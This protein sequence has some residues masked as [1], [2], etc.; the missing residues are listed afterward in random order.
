MVVT[1]TPMHVTDTP[2]P[3]AECTRE[4]KDAEREHSSPRQACHRLREH[5]HIALLGPRGP[6]DPTTNL[7]IRGRCLV[8]SLARAVLS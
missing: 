7:R 4:V 3:V 6:L 2:M 5:S 8:S 1:D